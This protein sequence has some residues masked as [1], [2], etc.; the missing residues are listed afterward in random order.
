MGTCKCYDLPPEGKFV[1][2]NI[3]HWGYVIDGI[4][5][6]DESNTDIYFDEI[7]F[8]WFFMKTD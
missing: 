8:L 6:T 1:I 5:V 4:Y 7:K 2:G 3:Y